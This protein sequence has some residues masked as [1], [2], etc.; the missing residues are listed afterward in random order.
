MGE[1]DMR[2]F[3]IAM[4]A[5]VG[6]LAAQHAWAA[7]P[8]STTFTVEADVANS[9]TVSAS[10]ISFG[11]ITSASVAAVANNGAAGI[12][13]TCTADG[14]YDVGLVGANTTGEGA[15]TLNNASQT[16]IPYHLYQ[17]SGASTIWG[18]TPG[19]DTLATQ[20]G[21]GT[22]AVG[23]CTGTG[24]AQDYEVWA[25]LGALPSPLHLGAYTDIVTVTV[26]YY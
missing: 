15:S 13:V 24:S 11:N 23:N 26:N 18:N 22:I 4:T 19:T 17:N 1:H 25:K 14:T 8:A 6:V 20:T 2:R 7:S 12:I 10:N 5:L 9:C 3:L 16:P 21:C